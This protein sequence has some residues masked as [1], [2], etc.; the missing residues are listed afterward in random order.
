V[1]IIV[2]SDTTLGSPNGFFR[3]YHHRL[4]FPD[5]NIILGDRDVIIFGEKIVSSAIPLKQKKKKYQTQGS[6]QEE[7]RRQQ[8]PL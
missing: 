7:G 2:F 8:F 6:T 4:L 1:L 5:E 3:V